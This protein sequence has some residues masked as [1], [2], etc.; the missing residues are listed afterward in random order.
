MIELKTD[1]NPD[2]AKIVREPSL[3]YEGISNG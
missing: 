3:K 1:R 2:I